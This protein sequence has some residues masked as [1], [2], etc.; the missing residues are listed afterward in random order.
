MELLGP[1][2][3]DFK[4]QS[5][6][7]RKRIV[8]Q[9]AVQMVHTLLCTVSHLRLN[10]GQISAL[11]HV[12]SHGIVHRDI[13]PGNILLCTTDRRCIRLVDFGLA[14]Q[15]RGQPVPIIGPCLEAEYVLGTLS[16]ASLHA[17][18]GFGESSHPCKWE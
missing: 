2:I 4:G 8:P 17:H 6:E 11:E 15:Y 16:Y 7:M 10:F 3:G 1:S 13:K 5:I 18:R 12:H 9:L 14:Y